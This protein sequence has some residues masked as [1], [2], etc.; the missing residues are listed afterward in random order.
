MDCKSLL[1][2][3][4]PLLLLCVGGSSVVARSN[5][6]DI[7]KELIHNAHGGM[8]L[9]DVDGRQ[10]Y[11]GYVGTGY[12]F[13]LDDKNRFYVYPAIDVKWGEYRADGGGFKSTSV[14]LPVTVGY[15]LF[16]TDLISMNLYGGATFEQ[17]IS[18]TDQQFDDKHVNRSQAGLT[19]GVS[20]RLAN[21]FSINAS[22]YY[23][24]TTLFNDG[25]SYTRSYN[26]SVNF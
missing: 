26:F 23:G 25:S 22:Y 6:D 9:H 18:I 7:L 20:I 10:S 15:E 12:R 11:S 16:N 24:L 2:Y 13:F 14:A 3:I 5:T 19:G 8:E 17:F 21:K 1:K 4:L